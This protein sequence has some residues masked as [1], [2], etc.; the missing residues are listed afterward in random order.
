MRHFKTFVVS[1][2]IFILTS[3]AGFTAVEFVEFE[4][5]FNA[6]FGISAA[7]SAEGPKEL[8]FI[9]AKDVPFKAGYLHSKTMR[10]MGGV[11]FRQVAKPAK[12]IANACPD[13]RIDLTQPNGTRLTAQLS[14]KKEVHG[15]IFDW[16]LIPTAEYVASGEDGLI[17]YMK[18]EAEYQ[19]AFSNNLVGL[20]LFLL[21]N[22]RQWTRFPYAHLFLKA[23]VVDGYP[24]SQPSDAGL[25]AWRVL[26]DFLGDEQLMFWDRDVNFVFSVN[27]QRLSISGEPYWVAVDEINKEGDGRVIRSFRDVA[28]A[29][30]SN[31]TIYDSIYRVAKYSAFFKYLAQKCDTV[32][33][34]FLTDLAAHRADMRE[35]QV[36]P[37]K[38]WS[39]VIN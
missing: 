9:A 16:E 22:S 5:D 21:D 6:K 17:S 8:A 13:V 20:N 37:N 14:A 39:K 3:A 1:A 15:E 4:D 18:Y 25:A 35:I 11:L 36:P 19:K 28:T 33:S 2:A 38:M 32:W 10:T 29:R 27:G 23:P 7:N 24:Q 30:L 31:P 12:D 26:R 34:R